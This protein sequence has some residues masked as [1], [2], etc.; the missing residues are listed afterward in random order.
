MCF[1]RLQ[2]VLGLC[3][4]SGISVG[5]SSDRSMTFWWSL[6]LLPNRIFLSGEAADPV[7]TLPF[8]FFVVVYIVNLN[9][10]VNV[11]LH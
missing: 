11:N 1:C 7:M 4:I 2:W 5:S 8:K 6:F 10:K 3:S 9:F